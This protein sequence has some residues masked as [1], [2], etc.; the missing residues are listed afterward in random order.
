MGILEIRHLR[1]IKA[2]TETENLTRAAK[3]FHVSQPALS[4]QLRELED[5]LGAV[6]FERT[7]K[8]MIVTRMGKLV[9]QAAEKVLTELDRVERDIAKA[10]HGE[11]GTIRV[12][13]HCVLS[14]QWLPGVMR[15]F[16]N[17]YPHVELVLNNSH[18]FIRD[19]KSDAFDLVI[20]AFPIDHPQMTHVRLFED[21]IVAVSSH[22]HPM[23]T[24]KTVH[25]SDFEGVT[26]I[27]LVEKS[28]DLLYQYYLAP[29]GIKIRQFMTIEQ[30]QAIID[31]VRSG[32]GIALFP[33]WSV[34]KFLKSGEL[35]A[36]SLGQGGV[37]LE[38]RAVYLKS[39]KFPVY[40]QEFL[41]LVAD[42]PLATLLQQ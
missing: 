11:T 36:S 37:R 25:E 14:F 28:K 22:S 20:T 1:L 32:F 23:S 29:A 4:Q 3:K 13:V 42:D 2:L 31:L 39:K 7:G 33:R 18:T 30:P 8:K 41:R 34:K 16:N 24:K 35:C 6:L 12:G 17:M 27:S 19:L 15:K 38:W 10:V 9:R 26:M 40:Q 21:E 5:R